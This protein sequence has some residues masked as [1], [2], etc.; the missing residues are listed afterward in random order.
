MKPRD[1]R[2]LNG[3][4]VIDAAEALYGEEMLCASREEHHALFG[5]DGDFE[6]DEEDDENFDEDDEDFDDDDEEW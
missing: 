4:G 3:D 2:D 1:F 6:D 5:D